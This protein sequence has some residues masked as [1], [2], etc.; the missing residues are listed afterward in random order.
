MEPITN[1]ISSTEFNHISY[2]VIQN[3]LSN[4]IMHNKIASS[5]QKHKALYNLCIGLYRTHIVSYISQQF[6]LDRIKDDFMEKI[7]LQL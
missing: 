3:C 4:F 2:E 5:N 1:Q 7:I 6:T